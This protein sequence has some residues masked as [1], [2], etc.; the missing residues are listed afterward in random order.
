MARL[1]VIYSGIKSSSEKNA[2]LIAQELV[3]FFHQ[4]DIFETSLAPHGVDLNRYDGV[5]FGS[6][7]ERWVKNNAELI[8]CKSNMSFAQAMNASEIE[9]FSRAFAQSQIPREFLEW[10][11]HLR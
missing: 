2:Y 3:D 5:I 4:V 6:G 8:F 7:T 11:H 9:N 1:L 10:G